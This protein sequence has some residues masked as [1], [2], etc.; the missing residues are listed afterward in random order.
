MTELVS[1]RFVVISDDRMSAALR[2]RIA[3]RVAPAPGLRARSKDGWRALAFAGDGELV[4]H[5][6]V[7]EV[8]G[9]PG[10][11]VFALRDVTVAPA[12]RGDHVVQRLCQLAT[13]TCWCCRADAIVANA[14][15]LGDALV[16]LGYAPLGSDGS[17]CAGRR[18]L[19]TSV[20]F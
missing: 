9:E 8:S 13:A 18:E 1:Y 16:L 4:G 19:A 6:A 17:M 20:V 15:G 7:V 11:R 10:A 12:H 14:T 2:E 5:A 3:T